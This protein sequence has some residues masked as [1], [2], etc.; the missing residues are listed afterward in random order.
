[1]L[2]PAPAITEI[3]TA[4]CAADA[5]KAC[6]SFG[7]D[8]VLLDVRMPGGDGFQALDEIRANWPEIHVIML[9]SSAT[10]PEV[11]LARL[12]GAAGYVGKSVDRSTLL[13]V[14]HR[15]AAGGTCFQ[16]DE[17]SAI[18]SAVLSP[19]ELEVL[20]HLG[21]GHGNEDLGRALGVSGET[22]K[23]HLKSIFQKLDV[24]GRAEAVARGYELGLLSRR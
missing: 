16:P 18:G 9:S 23:S 3:A 15:V 5:I 6:E 11:N 22:I 7:P 8:V 17:Q 2:S 19:R 4:A 20:R 24:S 14:I 10:A 21:S 13:D 12:H 1:M